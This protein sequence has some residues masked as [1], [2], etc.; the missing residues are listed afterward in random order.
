MYPLVINNYQP[1]SKIPSTIFSAV[2]ESFYKI[3]FKKLVFTSLDY[4]GVT[5]INCFA[6]FKLL[7]QS[8]LT[9]INQ[10]FINLD[11]L[12]G[13]LYLTNSN[14]FIQNVIIQINV[15]SNLFYFPQILLNQTCFQNSTII[16]TPLNFK[17][18]QIFVM[19][20]NQLPT[21]YFD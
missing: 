2:A 20:I 15:N 12:N 8:N 21:F 18:L 14:Q 3:K 17:F 7:Y 10:N 13:N 19:G 16:T 6:S 4:V 11:S 1:F 5:N 9:Q